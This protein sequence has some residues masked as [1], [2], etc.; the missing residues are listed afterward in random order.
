MKVG[1]FAGTTNEAALQNTGFFA[2]TRRE[3]F[4]LQRR[5]R[6][7][8]LVKKGAVSVLECGSYC[9]QEIVAS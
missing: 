4:G 5:L 3:K 6:S 9:V 7:K 2:C 8:G 1:S